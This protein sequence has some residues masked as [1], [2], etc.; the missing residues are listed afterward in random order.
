MPMQQRRAT[1]MLCPTWET[2]A[3]PYYCYWTA[4][5][6]TMKGREK[7]QLRSYRKVMSFLK[8]VLACV[9]YPLLLPPFGVWI[10]RRI[11]CYFVFVLFSFPPS[12]S[13]LPSDE[14]S[15]PS[16]SPWLASYSGSRCLVAFQSPRPGGF[17]GK[18]IS[19]II[20][21]WERVFLSALNMRENA[22]F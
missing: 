13:A 17:W 3:M 16:D 10:H 2:T 22:L 20:I 6:T 15:V 9:M 1:T 12:E 14:S 19:R 8:E 18:P 5:T 4:S 11:L 21:K 7:A